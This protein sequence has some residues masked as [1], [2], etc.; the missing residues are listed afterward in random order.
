[1]ITY[2]ISKKQARLFLLQHQGLISGGLPGG[3]TGIY[4]FVRHVGCIQYDPLNIAGHNHELVLQA[5]VPGFI[6]AQANELLYQDRLLTDG[7]DKNMSIYCT[8]DWPCFQRLREAASGHHQRNEPLE[9]TVLQ[10][11]DALS[12]RGPLSSLDLEGK[13]KIDWAWAP[14]RLSRAALETMYFRGEVSIHHR[15]HTRRYYDFTSRLLPEQVVAAADPNPTTEQYHDWYVQR[16]IGSIGLQWNKSGDGWLGISG[17]KSK[18]RTAAV[19]RLLQIDSLREVHVEG[20]KL[21]LYM[22]T[23]DAPELE[24]VLQLEEEAEDSGRS[25][26]TVNFAAALAPLDNL[27]WDRELI[28]Q[29]FGFHYRWEVYKPVVEREY[30][31]YVLPLLYGDRF[32]GRFEPVMNRKSGILTITRWWWEPEEVLTAEMVPALR[33][34]LSCLA[35][36]TGA[37]AIQFPPEVVKTCGLEALETA[38]L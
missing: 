23:M 11:R 3:K 25:H 33:Q 15:V 24:A 22:R 6:P 21:P 32:I 14:A 16:R 17:L 8:E 31:Y 20:I 38:S 28:R 37:S 36:C 7:W 2:N 35:R 4:E 9:A 19:Q 1:M 34:A 12:Q 29:L 26:S 10:V 27:L 13:E 5:R 18:E 30:G